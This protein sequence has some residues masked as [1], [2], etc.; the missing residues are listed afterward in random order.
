MCGMGTAC[1]E[2]PTLGWDCVVLTRF[3]LALIFFGYK[4]LNSKW[5][6]FIA[7]CGPNNRRNCQPQHR[8]WTNRLCR[9]PL[10]LA[11]VYFAVRKVAESRSTD[12][13]V[14]RTL[15]RCEDNDIDHG[16]RFV[17]ARGQNP[18]GVPSRSCPTKAGP[19]HK[20]CRS[21]NCAE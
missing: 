3:P 14:T 20:Y 7:C 21:R 9:T 12:N 18:E 17:V 16:R 5:R 15:I 10:R 19:P 11:R 13:S 4:I 6:K 2:N 8:R 1:I